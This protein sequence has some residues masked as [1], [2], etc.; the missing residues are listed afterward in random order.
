[1]SP[2]VHRVRLERGATAIRPF[3]RSDLDGLLALRLSNRAF[4]GPYEAD[5]SDAFFT[6]AGQA[7]EIALDTEA[8]AAGAGYAF[9]VLD[10]FADDRLIG[11]IALSNVVRGPWQNATLGYWVDEAANGRGHA[12]S[13]VHLLCRFAFEHAGLH[14]VQPAIMPRNARSRRVVTKVGFRHE[15]TALRYLKIA[16]VWED[17]D[18]FALTREDWRELG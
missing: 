1:M 13:G 16:G 7:R 3:S 2:A 14:R 4:M 8:W 18:I 6:R 15:G 17:H 10:R 5:R 9:A 11:R 12:T